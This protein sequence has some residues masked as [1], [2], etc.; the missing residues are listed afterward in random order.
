MNNDDPQ[1]ELVDGNTTIY[2]DTRKADNKSATSFEPID[3]LG[4]SFLS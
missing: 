4:L 3:T 1:A 2:L